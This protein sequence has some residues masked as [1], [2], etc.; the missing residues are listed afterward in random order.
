MVSVRKVKTVVERQW[1]ASFYTTWVR[2]C[3]E[4][5]KSPYQVK[6]TQLSLYKTFYGCNLRRGIVRCLLLLVT[7][8]LV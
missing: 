7:P 1:H 3:G 5:F 8:T 6:N 4:D 2:T